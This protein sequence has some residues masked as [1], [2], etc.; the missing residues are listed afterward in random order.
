[1]RVLVA[2]LLFLT[3]GK[4]FGQ[5][6]GIV[7]IERHCLDNTCSKKQKLQHT[8]NPNG[9]ILEY[10]IF[11]DYH[12]P[13]T[14]HLGYVSKYK[15]KHSKLLEL[16]HYTGERL[17]DLIRFS[18]KKGRLDSIQYHDGTAIKHLYDSKGNI[19]TTVMTK[20]SNALRIINYSYKKS[21]LSELYRYNNKIENEKIIYSKSGD[22][23]VERITRY[24]SVFID[25]PWVAIN[26]SKYEGKK[27]VY[28]SSFYEDDKSRDEKWITYDSG[29]NIKKAE[30]ISTTQDLVKKERADFF[31]RNGLISRIE[32]FELINNVWQPTYHIV[33][34]MEKPKIKLKDKIK[35]IIN[36]YFLGKYNAIL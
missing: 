12:R 31:Y 22:T 27:L 10:I 29:G 15:Y 5:D 35:K 26:K 8:F 3:L 4:S 7:I 19:A 23:L 28:A 2:V 32:E 13:D 25:K 24:D 14:T 21:E 1:M 36:L 11:G 18:Y 33:Y 9:D 17:S 16:T 34:E 6:N 20:D 30:F